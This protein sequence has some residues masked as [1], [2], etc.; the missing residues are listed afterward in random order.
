[1][2]ATLT[3][4]ATGES[5]RVH[6]DFLA[7]CDGGDSR[8]RTLAEIVTTGDSYPQTFV[9][10]DFAD[11]SGF[12]REAHLFFTRHGSVESFP[13]PGDRRR[14]IVQTLQLLR[15]PPPGLLVDTVRQ[16]TGVDL[17]DSDCSFE[18]AFAVR[19]RLA[20]RYFQGRVAL[21]G[22]A[23]HLMSPVGG[24]GMNV[25]FGDAVAL[26]GVLTRGLRR[27]A[28]AEPLLA[29]YSR[30]RQAVAKI[31]IDRAARGMWM[32]TRRGRLAGLWREPLLR[33]LLSPPLCRKLPA[34]F[35]MLTLPANPP[36][37]ENSP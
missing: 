7:G 17:V 32:G 12:G 19:H 36:A 23:A 1:V 25:G 31:A 29:D 37:P 27:G 22:D 14:W 26:A 28:D 15:P 20:Q 30:R 24:Q 2:T 6:S 35:A 5:E 18:S 8:A 4:P 21:C 9:M 33:L 10:A 11:A 34:Y 16:R 13:L 3:N